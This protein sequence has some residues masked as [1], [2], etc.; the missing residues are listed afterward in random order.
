MAHHAEPPETIAPAAD[1]MPPTPG[2]PGEPA[3]VVIEAPLDVRS[4]A[5]TVLAVIAVIFTLQTAQSVFIPIVIA[6]L[7]SYALGPMV[8]SFA[9]RGL[10]RVI[11]AAIAVVIVIA[12]AGIGTYTLTDQVL[13]IA[14]QVPVAAQ[15]VRERVREHRQQRGAL[16][17]VQRAATKVEKT[18]NGVASQ[19]AP[20]KPPSG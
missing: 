10:P 4:I 16:Q 17:T 8:A 12:A 5:L 13:Q 11:G 2:A 14:E 20:S 7:L 18:G 3:P 15:R 9:R 1:P 19:A 6:L